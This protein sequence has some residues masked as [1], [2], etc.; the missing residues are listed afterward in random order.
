MYHKINIVIFGIET[1]QKRKKNTKY[2]SYFS[3]ETVSR[4]PDAAL[5]VKGH[6]NK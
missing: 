1:P 4:V 5:K 3:Y 6:E 2:L